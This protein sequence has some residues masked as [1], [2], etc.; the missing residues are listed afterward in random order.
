MMMQ[1][2]QDREN[3]NLETLRRESDRREDAARREEDRKE[4]AARCAVERRDKAAQLEEER[5]ERE[6]DRTDRDRQH[7]QLL[8]ALFGGRSKLSPHPAI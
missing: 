7:S 8:L 6:I 5:K 3:R 4:E 2:Q 1:M